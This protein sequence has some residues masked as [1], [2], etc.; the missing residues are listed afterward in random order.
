MNPVEAGVISLI[1]S[2]PFY[3]ALLMHMPRVEAPDLVQLAGVRFKD[4]EVELLYNADAFE[5]LDAQETVGVLEHEC[6]H[7]VLKHLERRQGRDKL[8]A[9]GESVW[10]LWNIATDLAVNSIIE[11]PLPKDALKPGQFRLADGLSSEQ[12]YEALAKQLK[13]AAKDSQAEVLPVEGGDTWRK[14]SNRFPK[15]IDDHQHWSD[16]DDTAD[17]REETVRQMLDR[18]VS[19]ARGQGQGNVPAGLEAHIKALL[20]PAKIPWARLLRLYVGTAARAGHRSTWMRPSRRFD[21]DQKG[22]AA[23]RKLHVCL[24]IDTSGSISDRMLRRFAAEM[25]SIAKGYRSHVTVIECDAAVQKVYPLEK[26]RVDMD[27]KGRGGTDFRPVFD[28][29]KESRLKTN[30]LIYLTDL[31]GFFPERAPQYPVIWVATGPRDGIRV[32]FGRRLALEV[33]DEAV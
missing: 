26:L 32:P 7:V 18:A 9:L 33:E 4:G 20:E 6:L 22:R 1:K 16:G 31:L 24:A 15:V 28:Y 14:K 2:S 17:L 27:F 8:V 10:P 5:K 13:S 3:A 19:K 11:C 29:V 12:Y 23:V 21:E 25:R 30:L